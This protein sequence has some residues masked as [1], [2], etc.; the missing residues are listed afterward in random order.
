[1]LPLNKASIMNNTIKRVLV[2]LLSILIIF[3][4]IELLSLY[5]NNTF[6]FPSVKKILTAFFDVIKDYKTYLYIGNTLLNLLVS[7]IISFII[8]MIL[9]VLGGLFKYVRV[10]LKPWIT[11]LRSIPLASCIVIIMIIAGLNKT[12]YFVC[13]IMVMPIIYEGFCEGIINIDKSLMDFWRLNSKINLLVLTK[14]HFPLII[15]SIKLSFISAIGIGIK[16]VIMAEFLAGVK[17]TL[18]EA[19]I[20]YSDLIAYDYVWAYS[21]IMILIVIIIENLPYLIAYL[22]RYLR[23]KIASKTIYY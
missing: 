4:V 14:V 7:L 1:M 11:I 20:L 21:I 13:S 17:N 19:I 12:P 15:N 22:Y 5:I 6:I 3:V 8:G 10:F 18:G 23:D 16:V 9:G 2:Y